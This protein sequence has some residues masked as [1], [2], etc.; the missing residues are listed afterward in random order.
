[1]KSRGP[2]FAEEAYRQ[3]YNPAAGPLWS[4]TAGLAP[5]EDGDHYR[6]EHHFFE[7]WYFDAAFTNGYTLV[8]ILHSS[9]YNTADDKPTVDLRVYAPDGRRWLGIGR[10]ER[11]AMSSTGERCQVRIAHCQADGDGSHYQLR[12]CQGGIEAELEFQGSV[13]GWK[14]G[15]GYL[16]RDQ[17]SGRF[18]RWVVPLPRA[19]VAGWLRVDE[20]R[21]TVTGEGYHDHNWGN[22]YLPAAFSRWTWGRVLA[23]E[24]TLIF[25]DVVGRG[26]RPVHVTPFMLARNDE[27]L[28][29]TDRIF[30]REGD[31]A[32]EPR[33]GA[34][35]FRHLHLSSGE[36][37]GV[38]LVLRARRIMD[39]LDFA[40]PRLSLA[41]H[42]RLRGAAEMAF[43][44][45]QR[46]PFARQPVAWL[47]GKGSYLRWEADYRLE[48]SGHN[49]VEGNRA[50]YEV[51]IL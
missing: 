26:A 21:F 38:S 39:A 5:E 18:F 51:M 4:A 34:R 7:W 19:R 6:A 15:T 49:V 29:E 11:E 22:V 17:A 16:F 35:Y 25:G 40:A 2:L 47:L 10:F 48:L 12:L 13:P 32:R 30:I 3:L 36:G 43:Y 45:A 31:P 41:R 27:I 37:P 23:G 9:L 14:P 28:L 8:A 50:L 20:E 33:T 42:R 46:I 24:W 1:M 44:L